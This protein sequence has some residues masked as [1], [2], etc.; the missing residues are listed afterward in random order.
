[1]S[2]SFYQIDTRVIA[3]IFAIVFVSGGCVYL[4]IVLKKEKQSV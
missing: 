4:G 2:V 3:N 1:M